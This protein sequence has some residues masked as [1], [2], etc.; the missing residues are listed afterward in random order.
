MR[1]LRSLLAGLAVLAVT[2]SAADAGTI[3]IRSWDDATQRLGDLSTSLPYTGFRTS[4]LG[5][6]DT[7]LA[8]VSTLSAANLAGVDAFFWGTSSHVLSAAEAAALAAFV[9][10]GGRII[11]ETN[12]ITSEQ[13][14]ADS[15][16]TALG[17]GNRVGSLGNGVQGDNTG[18]FTA[19]TTLTTVG[20]FGDLRGAG[21]WSS[22]AAIIDPTGG[23][24]V[25]TWG[26]TN[27]NTTWVEFAVGAGWVLGVGDPYGIDL[28]SDPDNITGYMNF[29]HP[30]DQNVIPEP[31]TMALLGGGILV[32]IRRLRQRRA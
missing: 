22:V 24:P 7:I 20:L 25:G 3:T 32:G 21:F 6:G 11:I 29:L 19:A 26:T 18:T 27:P 4:L 15:G 10:G 1:V 12:S 9:N 31:G 5:N 17:L 28:F 16:Y 8:G 30:A 23:T 2:S 13:T 14:A